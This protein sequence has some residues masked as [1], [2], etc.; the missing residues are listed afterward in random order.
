MSAETD[1]TVPPNEHAVAIESL[2]PEIARRLFTLEPGSPLAELTNP[3]LKLV[4]L[5][6]T[7]RRTMTEV[8]AE[9]AISVSAATQL[10]DRLERAGLV[11]RTAENGEANNGGDRRLRYLALTQSG[12]ELLS[13]R[14]KQRQA[15]VTAVLS[16]LPA[17]DQAAIRAALETM[18]AA[19]VAR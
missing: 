19:T 7:G 8:A 4:S 3:Q 9:M 13:A 15:R 18:L 14:Q 12:E 11:G 1:T 10:A 2:L 5:L 6:L 16:R 17:G